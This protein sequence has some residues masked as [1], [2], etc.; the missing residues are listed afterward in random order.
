[1]Y[2]GVMDHTAKEGGQSVLTNMIHCN[3]IKVT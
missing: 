1:M 2:S 3:F